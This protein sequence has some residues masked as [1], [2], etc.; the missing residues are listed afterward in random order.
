MTTSLDLLIKP[1]TAAPHTQR[2]SRHRSRRRKRVALKVVLI[3]A[4]SIVG[5]AVVHFAF[6]AVRIAI[7]CPSAEHDDS[8]VT[9][10]PMSEGV[11]EEC[12]V[13]DAQSEDL[14]RWDAA[15]A[16]IAVIVLVWSTVVLRKLK[17]HRR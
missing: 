1:E 10:P 11:A 16:L 5:L 14:M 6:N 2:S 4:L 13:V 8:Q 7:S 12:R 9:T 17:P 15:A 3:V